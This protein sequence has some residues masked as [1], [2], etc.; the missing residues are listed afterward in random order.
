MD[1]NEFFDIPGFDGIYKINLNENI[2]SIGRWVNANKGGQ[3]Y[4]GDKILSN[5]KDRTGYWKVKLSKGNFLIHRLLAIT[6]IPNPLNFPL[7]RHLND[8]R[9]DNRI[10]NLAWGTKED[11]ALDSIKNGTFAFV[12][13]GENNH[14]YGR[15]GEK[16]PIYGRYRGNKS[17]CSKIVFDTQNGVFY[18]TV[19]DAA[20]AN[21]MLKGTLSARLL[22]RL[23][24]KTSLVYV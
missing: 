5:W 13:T 4:V 21:G 12:G 24:N 7:V 8:I 18:D 9:I 14:M 23:E 6:F 1:K 20:E 22:G 17:P 3:M 10:E 15:R 11:N 2:K 19:R 16:S